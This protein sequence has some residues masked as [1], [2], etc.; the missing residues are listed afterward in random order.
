MKTCLLLSVCIAFSFSV[1]AQL[2]NEWLRQNATQRKYLAQQIVAL[3]AHI[4][5]LKKG[6]DIAR[7]GYK[8]IHYIKNGEFSLHSGFFSGLKTVNPKIRKYQR[9]ADI[10]ANQ[11]TIIQACHANT[12]AVRKSGRFAPFEMDALSSVT[13]VLL[14]ESTKTIDQLSSVILN[15]RYKM[16][17]DERLMRIDKLFTQSTYQVQ[18]SLQ[19]SQQIRFINNNRSKDQTETVDMKTLYGL[20]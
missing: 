18:A 6:Y 16:S 20:H 1:N 5:Q 11:V 13:G 9:V 17:D 14:A 8:A 12:R 3:Q 10:I 4:I 19:L 15:G 7:K 2:V